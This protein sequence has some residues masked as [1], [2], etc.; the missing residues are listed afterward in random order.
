VQTRTLY[1]TMGDRVAHAAI[2]LTVLAL[3]ASFRRPWLSSSMN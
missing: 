2:I 1:A 3:A